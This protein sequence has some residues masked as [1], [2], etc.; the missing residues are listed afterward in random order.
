MPCLTYS[1]TNTFLIPALAEDQ[2][3]G[4][5]ALSHIHLFIQGSRI[6]FFLSVYIL[7]QERAILEF[8]SHIAMQFEVAEQQDE[9]PRTV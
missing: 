2:T 6:K 9:Q 5:I 3:D 4:R 7:R 1:L 8:N